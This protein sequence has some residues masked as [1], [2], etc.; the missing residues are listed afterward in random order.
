[1][2]THCACHYVLKSNTSYPE[3]TWQLCSRPGKDESSLRSLKLAG[4]MYICTFQII[5]FLPIQF[6]AQQYYLGNKNR[7]KMFKMEVLRYNYRFPKHQYV[8]LK[9]N[10]SIWIKWKQWF[11]LKGQNSGIHTSPRGIKRNFRTDHSQVGLNY[12]WLTE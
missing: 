4:H 2:C 11:L 1:M 8:R 6:T 12:I 9:C 3:I 10:E 5:F 7:C